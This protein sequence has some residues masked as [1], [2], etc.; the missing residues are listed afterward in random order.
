MIGILLYAYFLLLGFLYANMLF[1]KKDIYFRIWI[2]GITGNV[3]LMVGILPFAFLLRFSVAA[4]ILLAVFAVVPYLIIKLRK[5][6]KLIAVMVKGG[7]EYIP[8]K[9]FLFVILPIALIIWILMTNH[10]LAPYENGG[11]SSGQCTYGDLHM[12]LSFITSIAEQKDFPPMY[13]QLSGTSLNYPFFVDMLSSSL[14]LFGTPLRWAVLVPSYVISLLLVMGFYILSYTLTGKKSVAVLASVLFFLNGGFGF[15]Y[16][17]DGSK[18]DPTLFTRIFKDYYHTPTNYTDGNIRWVNTICDMIIPQRTTMAGWCM[19][20]P[21]L[22]LLIEAVKS[23]KRSL[24]IMLG[25]LAGCMP[26]IHTHSFL[27][28]G[29]IS[30][31][32][33]FAYLYGEKDRVGYIKNWVIY[34]AIVFV[35]AFPQLMFWTF[36]QTSGNESFLRWSFNWVNKN[37]PY[38]WFYLKN[39]GII[40]LFLIPAVLHTSKENKKLLAGCALILLIAE[41][42]V[43]QPNEYDNNKLIFIVFMMCVIFVS[44][45]LVYLCD[46]L[47]EVRGRAFFAVVVVLAGTLSGALTIGREYVSGGQYQTFTEDDIEFSEY[48]KENTDPHAVFLTGTE[49]TNPISALAGRTIYLGSSAYV[50]FHGFGEEFSKRDQEVKNA[51]SGTYEEMK[52]LCDENGITYIFVGRSERNDYSINENMLSKMEKIYSKGGNTLYKVN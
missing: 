22:W 7:E 45:Y 8:H 33:F 49:V 36:R 17:I 39:W 6:E 46:K 30:A 25:I 13:C 52:K 50:Y 38:F 14:H 44:D 42:I 51:Y 28:L 3:L 19:I 12:H 15:A 4:H 20:I 9:I 31:V 47:K 24:Y 27:A 10:I 40:A 16:F 41:T 35:M 26:M 29:I 32:M 48:V 18:A 37:D 11:V 23:K 43:F 1:S 21:A 5:K 2:G 34:G